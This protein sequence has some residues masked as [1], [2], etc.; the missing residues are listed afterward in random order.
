MQ[1][2]AAPAKITVPFANSG[3]KNSIP[4]A[5]QIGI[6]PG[7]A[8]FTDGFPPLTRTP[9]A[10]GGVPPA[11]LDMNGILYDVSAIVQ[12]AN[13]GAGYVYDAAFSTAVGG[14]AQGARVLR[15]DG[16]GYWLNTVDNNTTAP[17]SG[18]AGWVPDDGVYGVAAVTMTNANVTL[19]ALQ[20]GQQIIKITGTLTTN[21]NLIFPALSGQWVVLN[22]TT[23]AYS[24]TCKTAA[25]TGVAVSG[26]QPVV[27]DGT[28]IYASTLT[29]SLLAS[30]NLSDLGSLSTALSNLGFTNS[31]GASGYQKL[32]GGLIIQWS[33]AGAAP[34]SVTFPLTFPTACFGVTATSNQ[35]AYD[36]QGIGITSLTTSGFDYGNLG[37]TGQ[38]RNFTA[39]W[40]ALGN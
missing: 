27:G 32:P 6:T 1:L 11:G 14:Y 5:S 34:S 33:A 18:G 19:T 37:Y 24:I 16:N 10:S 29:G 13:G 25:G 7:A 38:N 35:A 12:W 22:R 26:T 20:Y 4:V 40:I 28:N 31:L 36:E 8:S 21:V 17:E 23:G 30:N 15:S 9:V 2:S 39:F 3:G